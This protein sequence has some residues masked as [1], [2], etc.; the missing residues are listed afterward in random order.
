MNKIILS[1]Q[2]LQCLRTGKRIPGSIFLL[3]VNDEVVIGFNQYRRNSAK[4]RPDQLLLPLPHGWVRK[5]AQRYKLHL[6]LPDALGE[7]RVAEIMGTET[8]EAGH[9]L[10]ALEAILQNVA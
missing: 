5:S 10:R 7:R 4:R 8:E 9:F 2:L 6:S 1:E 3:Q